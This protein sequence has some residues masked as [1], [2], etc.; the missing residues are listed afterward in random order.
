MNNLSSEYSMKKNEFECV[1]G[2]QR[3]TAYELGIGN[4]RSKK[5]MS[6]YLDIKYGSTYMY[7]LNCFENHSLLHPCKG[8]KNDGKRCNINVHPKNKFCFYHR[9]QLQ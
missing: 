9:N 5:C 2:K 6:C 3:K 1:T 4:Q 7:C 8:Q